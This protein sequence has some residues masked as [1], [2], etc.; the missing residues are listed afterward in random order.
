MGDKVDGMR[1][2]SWFLFPSVVLLPM[3]GRLQK[4]EAGEEGA[5]TPDIGLDT[6]NS[7]RFIVQVDILKSFVVAKVV[8][9]D[10]GSQEK[11]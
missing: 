9:A 7:F 5:A 2:K 8:H 3:A 11:P 1:E 10:L 4:M 6:G